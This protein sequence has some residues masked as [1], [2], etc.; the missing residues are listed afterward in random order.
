MKQTT[1]CGSAH[2]RKKHEWHE[3]G[4]FLKAENCGA[5][6]GNRT[7]QE[8]RE[9]DKRMLETILTIRAKSA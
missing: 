7:E 4:L 3:S 6:N 8:L 9:S 2:C 5:T 1:Y